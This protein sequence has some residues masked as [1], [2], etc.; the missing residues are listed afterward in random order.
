MFHCE[1][2]VRID[3]IDVQNLLW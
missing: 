1:F 3:D 2:R